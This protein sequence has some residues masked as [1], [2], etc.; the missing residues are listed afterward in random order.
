MSNAPRRTPPPDQAQRERRSTRPAP[1]SCRPPPARAK[2]TLLTAAFLR[3]LGE[4]EEPGQIVAIT[5]TKAAAAEMRHR[6]LDE[7]EK[8]SPSPR[9]PR[10]RSRAFAGSRLES[11]RPARATSHLHHRLFLPRPC[12]AATAA[13]RLGGAWASKS[14][15]ANSIAARLAARLRRSAMPI[16]P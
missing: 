5:F 3:L 16:R 13:H 8:T 10:T 4:V 15:R 11:P 7:L 14:S 2:P 12:A 6:I 1:F 9:R